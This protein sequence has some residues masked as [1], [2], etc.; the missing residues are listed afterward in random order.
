MSADLA[1]ARHPSLQPRPDPWINGIGWGVFILG[2]CASAWWQSPPEQTG[3]RAAI[4]PLKQ[5][6]VACPICDGTGDVCHRFRPPNDDNP[7]LD[8]PYCPCCRGAGRLTQAE[9]DRYLGGP[10]GAAVDRDTDMRSDGGRVCGTCGGRGT[11]DR[12]CHR[13]GGTGS[14]HEGTLHAVWCSNCSGSGRKVESCFTCGG[15]G[16]TR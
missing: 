15:T 14:A 8:P 12:T 11:T 16:Q 2:V 1:S 13:C 3:P 6:L 5:A 9:L 4:A 7:Y 10:S